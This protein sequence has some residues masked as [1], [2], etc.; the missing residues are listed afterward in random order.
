MSNFGKNEKG[1]ALLLAMI[2]SGIVVTIGVS[3]LSITLKQVKLGI[4]TDNSE[5]AF[6]A[7]AAGMD[8]LRYIRNEQFDNFTENNRTVSINCFDLSSQTMSDSLAGTD[9]QKPYRQQFQTQ[10]DWDTGSENDICMRFEVY[11]LNALTAD[12]TWPTTDRGSLDCDEGDICTFAFV[13]ANNVACG[14]VTGNPRAVVRELS[15]KF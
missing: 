6:Q 3:I 5:R 1:F 7:A 4:G 15:A 14:D 2:V 12:K 8:C 13:Q 10:F 9:G 11:V